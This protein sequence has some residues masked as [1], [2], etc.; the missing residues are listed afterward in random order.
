MS[1]RVRKID[2]V[3]QDVIDLINERR[4]LT[5][6]VRWRTPID[7]PNR[8]AAPLLFAMLEDVLDEYDV[9]LQALSIRCGLSPQTLKFWMQAHGAPGLPPSFRD[10]PGRGRIAPAKRS[11]GASCKRGH[12]LT[13]SSSYWQGSYLQC[14]PCRALTARLRY[15]STSTTNRKAT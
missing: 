15:A 11:Y 13:E 5:A 8:A 3:P 2:L 7:H 12:V 14:K 1:D 9:S 6:R 4:K 10:K